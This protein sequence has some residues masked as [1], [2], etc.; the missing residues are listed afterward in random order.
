MAK[1]TYKIDPRPDTVIILKN[2][3]VDFAPWDSI[4]TTP[5]VDELVVD[6]PYTNG[7]ADYDPIIE[8]STADAPTN[9]ESAIQDADLGQNTHLAETVGEEM[10]E[11]Y[12]YYVSSRHLTLASPPL[13]NLLTGEKWKEGIRNGSDGLYHVPA[14]D[15]DSEALHILLKVLHHHN[16]QV[17]RKVTLELLAKITVLI[18]YYG[19]G[20]ALEP[21]T[22]GWVEHLKVASPIPSHFCRDLM[23]WMCVAWVLRLPHEFQ[24]TTT[25]AI[26][27][28]YR[29]L[30]TLGLPITICFGVYANSCRSIME[31]NFTRQD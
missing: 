11:E 30:P 25:V 29:D 27:R 28:Q 26:R 13:E 17:P 5:I 15:W 8:E 10:E 12:H 14:Q 4:E 1:V 9:G 18:D 6:E 3:N 7:L 22:E 2:P 23:L 20:E 31:T 21:F 24:R 19:C 16:R